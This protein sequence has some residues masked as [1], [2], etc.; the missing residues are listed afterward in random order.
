MKQQSKNPEPLEGIAPLI[1]AVQIKDIRLVEASV[2]TSVR[3]ANEAGEIELTIRR[4]ADIKEY[5]K[6]AGLFWVLAKIKT[7]L[8]PIERQK[9]TAVFVNAAFEIKYSLP[10]ELEVSQEQLNTFAGIN[11]VF[12]AW[13]YWREF[14]QSMIAR[15]NLPPVT[16]PVF[17]LETTKKV[18]RK[19]PAEVQ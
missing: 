1:K 11:S 9:D 7:R 14:V 4:S 15:M 10:K 3:S 5:N 13:P 6:D 16:L 12:N 19:K 18:R 17:R 8:I 2:G